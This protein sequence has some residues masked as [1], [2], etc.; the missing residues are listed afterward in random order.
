VLCG[1]VAFAASTAWLAQQSYRI[2]YEYG[3]IA[4]AGMA[5]LALFGLGAPRASAPR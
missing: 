5:A 1:Q 3:R 2:P 4:K